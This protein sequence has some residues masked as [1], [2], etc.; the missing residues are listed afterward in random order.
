MDSN[1]DFDDVFGGP[2]RRSSVQETRYSFCE[3][4]ESSSG[5]RTSDETVVAPR[6]S[7]SGLSEKPVF[8]E[9]G[10]MM[11]R[12]RYSKNDFFGDIFGG[13]Q[14]LTSS[15]R[16]Y[17]MKDPFAP[18]SQLM[19]P[20]RPLPPKAEPFATSAPSQFSLPAK[21]N[22]GTDLAD[23]A[24]KSK[25]WSLN[26]SS[27]YAY[28]PMSRFSGQANRDKDK[29]MRSNFQGNSKEDSISSGIPGN[30]NQFHFSIY[31]WA[32]KGGLPFP[33]PLRGNYRL[34]EKD[35][36]QRCS[37]ANGWI[38]CESIAME[39]KANLHNNF[40]STDRLS[41]H[42]MNEHGSPNDMRNKDDEP[43]QIIEEETYKPPRKPLNLFFDNEDVN[44]QGHDEIKKNAETSEKKKKEKKSSENLD[45]KSVKKQ[46]KNKTATSNNVG[47]STMNVKSS[48]RNSWDNGKGRVRGNVKEFIKIFNQETSPKPRADNHSSRL[49][50][51]HNVKPETEPNISM[52]EK[53]EKFYMPNLQ[54]KKKSPDVPVGNQ[55]NTNGSAKATVSDGSK[56]IAEDPTEPSEINFSI[57]DL[58]PEEE[59]VLPQHGI[60]Y[61]E[62]Q[63]IDAKIRQWSNGKQGN[64]RSLL[65][66]LQYVLWADSG[67]K[68]VPL[69][70][71]IEGRTVKKSYQKALLCLH[72]DKL[73]QK[74]AAPYK[75]YIAEKVFDIL[76]DAW[77]Q[78]NTLGSI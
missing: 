50:Q 12:R 56:T 73:Q 26:G 28:S 30:D 19:S 36:L 9:E 33:I 71:I 53:D 29:E 14:S 65:S 49:K 67:W 7:W 6:D 66:T 43:V 62:I 58:T 60:D 2:P 1:S 23:P 25:D 64:I 31:K 38:A 46:D 44:E 52:S 20:C 77:D 54:H 78:F 55:I 34:K 21:L 18:V 24:S 11:N 75:K 39:P 5:F 51:R 15:P 16:K 35:K 72:P 59:K 41:L 45:G 13:S 57:E 17:E 40:S 27:N 69:S 37:S 70:D 22:K 42:D 47:T 8:G 63:A 74:G 4:M 61:E 32:N 76:Q 10:M 3:N 48:P 68:P